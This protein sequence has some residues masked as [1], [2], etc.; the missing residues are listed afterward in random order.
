MSP[1]VPSLSSGIVEYDVG[2]YAKLGT[3]ALGKG[4]GNAE[5]SAHD[6][7]EPRLVDAKKS[8]TEGPS[9]LSYIAIHLY[10]RNTV[11]KELF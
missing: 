10:M 5:A 8:G 2:I 1:D 9:V 11:L 6:L 4:H 7:T 3:E